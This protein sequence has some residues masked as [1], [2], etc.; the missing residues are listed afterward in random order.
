MPLT[1][2]WIGVDGR[3]VATADMDPCL[4]RGSDCPSYEPGAT[5]RWAVE[6]PQHLT[7]IDMVF[8]PSSHVKSCHLHASRAIQLR[9]EAPAEW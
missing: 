5:Y 6:V 8:P 4:D 1:I 2:A 7:L 9:V 3:V